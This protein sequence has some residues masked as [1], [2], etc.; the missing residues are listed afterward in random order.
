MTSLLERTPEHDRTASLT[1]AARAFRAPLLVGLL[2][3]TISLVGIGT[4]SIWYDEAATVTAV[5]RSWP[6]LWAMLGNVDAVHAVYYFLIHALVDIFGYSPTVMRAPSAVAV[7]VAATL[8]VVLARQFERDGAA[9]LAGVVFCLLPRTTWMGT[10]ARSYAMTAALAVLLTIVFVRAVRS[11]GPRAWVLYSLVAATSV[12]VFVYL[13]LI[14]IAHGVTLAWWW[15]ATHRDASV[16]AVTVVRRWFVGSV[17]AAALLAPFVFV[18]ISQTGQVHWIDPLSWTSWREVFQTQ[19]FQY[20]PAYAVAGWVLIIFGI[21]TRLRRRFSGLPQMLVILPAIV[22]P[23]AVLLVATAVYTPLYTPRYVT[24]CLPF[25]A[26]AI[27]AGIAALRGRVVIGAVIASVVIL[28]IPPIIEQRAVEA[29]Q[30]SSWKEVAAFIGTERAADVGETT[31][32][33]YGAVKHHPTATSRV[34]A[35]SYPDSFVGTI[36]VTLDTPAARTAQLWE[37]RHPLDEV[38]DR[39][40]GADVAYLITS[41]TRDER[42]VTTEALAGIGWHVV[43]ER[44]F[45]DVNVLR[46]E[47]G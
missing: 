15:L 26:I 7:G 16:D 36:D 44:H 38:L 41:T 34:I 23:T 1:A 21:A 8:T 10:E 4:P 39:L 19:W 37:T 32:I 25:A 27:G 29:K 3:L 33:I 18:V 22:V 11:G 14:V 35:Y 45:T 2:G 40:S 12:L 46:Y 13:A 31:A 6:E 28:A 5:T 24:M 9:V 42:P 43:E 47:R 30:E 20:S 17:A